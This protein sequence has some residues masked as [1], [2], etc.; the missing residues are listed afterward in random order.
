MSRTTITT[1]KGI[2]IMNNKKKK[3][4]REAIQQRKTFVVTPK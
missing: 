3:K 4:E 1:T 2:E